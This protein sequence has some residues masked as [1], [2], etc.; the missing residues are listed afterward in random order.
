MKQTNAA[1]IQQEFNLSL[2]TW[3]QAK[4]QADELGLSVSENVSLLVDEDK[5]PAR[6]K[7]KVLTFPAPLSQEAEARYNRE[8]AEFEEQE[9]KHPQK[10]AA[11]VETD[12][13]PFIENPLYLP[14]VKD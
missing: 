13:E 14:L 5:N 8:I 6:R 4:A 3:L 11:T 9:K 7:K 10:G 12:F 2:S 1:D